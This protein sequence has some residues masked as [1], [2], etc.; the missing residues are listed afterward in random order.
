MNESDSSKQS[1]KDMP[2]NIGKDNNPEQSTNTVLNVGGSS[3][4][5]N[6]EN[7]EQKKQNSNTST[8]GNTNADNTLQDYIAQ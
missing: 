3:F 7:E 8:E 2:G 1:N 6:S 4:A 5:E